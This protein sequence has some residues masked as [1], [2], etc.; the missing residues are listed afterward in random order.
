MMS[1]PEI[2][3]SPLLGRALGSNTN[4]FAIFEVN[5]PGPL[6]G[7]SIR[8]VPLH[9]HR[10]EDEAWYILEGTLRFL[11]GERE[12]EAVAGSGILLPHGTPH[13]FWNPGPGPSRYLLIV[14]P[15]TAALLDVLHGSTRPDPSLLKQLS[16]SHGIELLE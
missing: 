8:G 12:F 16:A 9:L 4:D 13:T 6:L 2:V 11:S 15:K 5:D 7:R 1:R 10:T 14:R 3:E